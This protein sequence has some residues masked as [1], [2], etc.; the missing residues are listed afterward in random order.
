MRKNIAGVVLAGGRATR[1]GGGDKCLLPLGGETVLAHVI[2]RLGP[3]VATLALNANEDSAR[4]AAFG[5]PV[6]ADNIAGFAGPLA[7]ILAGLDWARQHGGGISVVVTV[8]GDTPFLPKDLVAR[9]LAAREETG[10]E[11]CVA[12]S[13]AGMHP[14]IGLWPLGIADV[15]R[16]ALAQGLRKA[17]RWAEQQDAVE[18]FFPPERIGGKEI[19]PFFNINQ[20]EDLAAADAI[21]APRAAAK[22]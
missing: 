2:A 9:F 6:I 8:A 18:V 21:L 19:D 5:L 1:M 11:I 14:V 3:Q 12:R 20:P 10:G 17:T 15:L 7:G 4:F 13:A 22:G 16:D